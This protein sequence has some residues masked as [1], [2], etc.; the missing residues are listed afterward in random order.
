MIHS[1]GW[2]AGSYGKELTSNLLTV[3]QGGGGGWVVW[4]R[5]LHIPPLST[6]VIICQVCDFSIG[7]VGW[8]KVFEKVLLAVM[9]TEGHSFLLAL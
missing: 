5:T 9:L 1:Q 7:R 6:S 3:D 2:L 8:W 4:C